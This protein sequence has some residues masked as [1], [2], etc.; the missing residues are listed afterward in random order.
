MTPDGYALWTPI[1]DAA[2]DAGQ[3]A[4]APGCQP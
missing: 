1:V 4:K 2:L 3:H